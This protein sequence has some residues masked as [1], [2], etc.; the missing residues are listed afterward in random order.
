[1]K[2]ISLT[3]NKFALI[4]DSNFDEFSKHKWY[5]LKTRNTSYAVRYENKKAILMH[6]EIMRPETGFCVDHINGNTLDNQRVNLRN[7]T[8]QQNMA[9][10]LKRRIFSSYYKGVYWD[11][12]K[13]KWM[14][15]IQINRK[16]K[17]LGRFDS[18]ILA[19]RA[20]DSAA[21]KFFG[22]FALLNFAN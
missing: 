9:H 10:R 6:R 19:A 15:V 5:A 3:Q 14:S 2:E 7:A 16:R 1:M 8:H 12:S 18:E 13:K 17:K 20:Y 22:E 21:I 11:K 4:D